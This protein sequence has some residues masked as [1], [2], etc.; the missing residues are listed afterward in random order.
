MVYFAHTFEENTLIGVLKQGTIINKVVWLAISLQEKIY[1]RKKK[2]R[3]R[4]VVG[5]GK[6]HQA[7]KDWSVF[8]QLPC[9]KILSISDKSMI[10]S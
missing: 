4:K 8:Y 5:I 2:H 9:D 1:I 7:R 10:S 3:G 6:L